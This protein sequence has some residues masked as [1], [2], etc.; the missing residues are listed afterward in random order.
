MRKLWIDDVRPPPEGWEWAK[1]G[2]DALDMLREN[3]YDEVSFDNDLG[4]GDEGYKV[5]DWLEME[6]WM[7][8]RRA[9]KLCH[10]HSMNPVAAERIRATLRR[11]TL[12]S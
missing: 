6:V 8:H 3:T 10:V 7:G 2:K 11:F 1:T 9:P 5:A 4:P 12:V